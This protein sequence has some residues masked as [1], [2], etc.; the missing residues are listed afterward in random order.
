MSFLLLQLPVALSFA[1]VLFFYTRPKQKGPYPPGPPPRFLL[2]NILDFPRYAQWDTFTK[3]KEQYGELVFL[4]ILGK[5]YLILSS[6]EACNDLLCRRGAYYSDRPKS[7]ML[8]EL[9]QFERSILLM[10]SEDADFKTNQKLIQSVLN[11]SAV[12]HYLK[13][14]EAS[15]AQMLNE[16]LRDPENHLIHFERASAKTALRVMYGVDLDEKDIDQR[17]EAVMAVTGNVSPVEFIVD[18]MPFLKHLPSWAPWHKKAAYL[19]TM[20]EKMM[21]EAFHRCEQDIDN[22]VAA[23]SF[24]SRIL[25]DPENI[26][27]GPHFREVLKWC[28]G[29][30]SAGGETAPVITNVFLWAMCLHPEPQKK[31]QAEIDAIIGSERLPNTADKDRLPYLR[32]L[33]NEIMRWYLVNFSFFP[34]IGLISFLQQITPLA[35]PHCLTRDDHYKGYY[36]PKGTIVIGNSFSI[37]QSESGPEPE[38]FRPERFLDGSCTV[39]PR[40]YVFGYGRRRCPGRQMAEDTIF[41]NV[42]ALLSC[43]DVTPKYKNLSPPN[44][45]GGLILNKPGPCPCNVAP[46]SEEKRAL[47]VSTAL[48]LSTVSTL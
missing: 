23:E 30:M 27:K 19:K 13:L 12:R 9:A 16:V 8:G 1:C 35:A 45:N 46:R 28:A 32:A 22:G 36:I 10:S 21:N 39:D 31:A 38:K 40:D 29:S 43:F 18:V 26:A 20:M 2:G 48:A 11:P 3:W 41:L 44:R 42:S 5:K 17:Q 47:I 6:M 24:V 7:V 34:T 37:A 25:Q 15:S 33:I 14:Q 4:H